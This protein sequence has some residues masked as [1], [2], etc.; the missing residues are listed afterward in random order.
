MAAVFFQQLSYHLRGESGKSSLGKFLLEACCSSLQDSPR[1]EPSLLPA[2]LPARDPAALG[3]R[4]ALALG[5]RDPS[6]LAATDPAAD[7]A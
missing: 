2:L 5:A 6:L 3:A 4:E 7:G 1:G